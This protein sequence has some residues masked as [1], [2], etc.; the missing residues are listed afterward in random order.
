MFFPQQV[1]SPNLPNASIYGDKALRGWKWEFDGNQGLYHAL[2]PRAWTVY[3]IPEHKIKLT[4]RQIS[5]VFP[6]DYKVTKILTPFSLF[7]YLFGEERFFLVDFT[8]RYWRT[9]AKSKAIDNEFCS[10][11]FVLNKMYH[12]VHERYS[13]SGSHKIKGLNMSTSL[14]YFLVYYLCLLLD[15]MTFNFWDRKST[16][17]NFTFFARFIMAAS[18]Q[19]GH[20]RQVSWLG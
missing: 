1:L 8:T 19:Y 4:C 18:G 9:K 20:V 5:P 15:S 17:I 14:N 13:V 16:I 10:R 12:Q 6:H 11:K 7:S 3:E 2:Y